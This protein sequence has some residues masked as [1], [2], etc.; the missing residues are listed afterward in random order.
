VADFLTL[1]NQNSGAIQIMFSGLVTIAT[2][3]YAYS[4]ERLL[5]SLGVMGGA[6]LRAFLTGSLPN[7]THPELRLNLDILCDSI[8]ISSKKGF[9]KS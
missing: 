2:V 6:P 1:L 5:T 9:T 8:S 7:V 4:E 3:V